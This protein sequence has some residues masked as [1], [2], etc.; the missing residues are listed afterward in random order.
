MYI[1]STRL[2]FYKFYIHEQHDED[3]KEPLVQG[4]DCE[5]AIS[6]PEMSTFQ[7]VCKIW[8]WIITIFA[9]FTVTL[10]LFPS[11]T[12]LVESVGKGQGNAWN[13]VYFTPVACFLVYNLGDYIGRVM[14]TTLP[15]PKDP[16]A[17]SYPMMIASVLRIAFIPLFL[18]CN[19]S[20]LN[21]SVTDVYFKSDTAFIVLMVL[22]SVSNGYIQ[23]ICL[24]FGPKVLTN[25][26]EQSRAASILVFYLVFGLTIGALLSAP[27]LSLL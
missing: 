15:W 22:F 6:Q 9:T 18:F 12:V 7:I 17:G 11:V 19:A 24:M 2:R 10:V 1:A 4:I 25:P 16:N 26:I 5:D 14:S 13:D 23:S 20:P 21:R 8:P 3:D 27:L